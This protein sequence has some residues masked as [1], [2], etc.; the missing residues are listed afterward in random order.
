MAKMTY[1]F[2]LQTKNLRREPPNKNARDTVQENI[3]RCKV[4]RVCGMKKPP[5]S[6]KNI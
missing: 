1:L 2:S 5:R 4:T 6:R 3:H